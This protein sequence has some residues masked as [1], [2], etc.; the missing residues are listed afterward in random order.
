M[1]TPA[2]APSVLIIDDD[3]RFRGRLAKAF[4]SRGYDAREAGN[5]EEAMK[6]T[7]QESAEFAVVDLRLPSGSG[8]SLVQLLHEADPSTRIVLLTGY[9]SM[10]TALEAVRRGATQYLTKPADVDELIAAFQGMETAV[11]RGLGAKPA[12]SEETSG[13]DIHHALADCGGDVFEAAKRLGIHH[14]LLQ[15]KLP[16]VLGLGVTPE[17]DK[18]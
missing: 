7:E 6:L 11:P 4:E 12:G 10:A 5:H 14:R 16:Q 15:R 18:H 13:E 9:G 3:E 1:T 2:P 8:L 17:H